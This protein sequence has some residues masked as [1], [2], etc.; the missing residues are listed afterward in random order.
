VFV[1]LFG[2]PSGVASCLAQ[3]TLEEVLSQPLA[4][5]ESITDQHRRFVRSRLVPLK[6]AASAE[7]WQR[8]A[9]QLRQRGMDEVVFRGVSAEWRQGKPN[10]VWHDVIETDD[11]Y[12]IR[13]L[14]FEALPD[15]WIPA[16]LYEPDKLQNKVPAILNVNG[17]SPTGK[18]TE[19]K[20][21][22]CINLAKRG[23]LALNLEWLG[24]GQL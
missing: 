14:R 20:Q 5:P 19:A 23:M 2:A 24:M 7:D 22:R 1:V 4:G 8:Q 10:V 21:L 18:S 12:R 6:P 13:K 11:G 15:L 3:A 16:L 9:E 17:H